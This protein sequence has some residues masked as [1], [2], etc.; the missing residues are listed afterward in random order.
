MIHTFH[1]H[2]DEQG[3]SPFFEKNLFISFECDN[4]IHIKVHSFVALLSITK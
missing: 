2:P 3:I 1:W 4:L